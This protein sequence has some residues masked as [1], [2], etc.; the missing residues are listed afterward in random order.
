MKCQCGSGSHAADCPEFAGLRGID[1]KRRLLGFFGAKGQKNLVLRVVDIVEMSPAAQ[2]SAMGMVALCQQ[3]PTF[4]P[5]NDWKRWWLSQ[6]PSGYV[7]LPI[8][9]LLD[10]L[11]LAEVAKIQQ[12]VAEYRNVRQ[13]K[14]SPCRKDP[15]DKCGGRGCDQCD[16]GVVFTFLEMDE[17]EIALARGDAA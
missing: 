9:K 7:V 1:D 16:D 17:A 10:P 5:G 2:S 11:P 13:G 12:V 14:G 4:P 6:F 15:C 8:E 3:I